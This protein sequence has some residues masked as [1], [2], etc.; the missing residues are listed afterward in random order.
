MSRLKFSRRD[1]VIGALAG[2]VTGAGVM[3]ALLR[4]SVSNPSDLSGGSVFHT[5]RAARI[6]TLSY[7]AVDNA[8]CTGCGICEAECTLWR[9]KTFD[10]WGS[11]IRIRHFE[12]SL[13]IASICASCNDAPCIAACPKEAGALS[14]D[15][16]TGA[17]LLSNSK[18]IGC[19]ACLKVCAK[20]RSDVIRMSRDGKKAVGIC[21]LCGGDPACVK[22][23]PEQCLSLVPANQN[24]IHFAASPEKIARSLSHGIYRSGRAD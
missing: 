17:I 6:T 23:C 1:F 3:S 5:D 9:E 16:L 13:D 4:K 22:V 15:P 18:C 21:D 11:R 10:T 14:R 19:G 12:P 7:I 24:G 20:D 2:S 8:R